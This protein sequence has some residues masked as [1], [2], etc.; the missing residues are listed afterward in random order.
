MVGIIIE[1]E[2]IE[3]EI[4]V[5]EMKGEEDPVPILQEDLL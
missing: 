5:G 3:I 4:I 2:E 1:T